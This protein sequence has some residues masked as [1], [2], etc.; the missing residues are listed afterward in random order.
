MI[1]DQLSLS[2]LPLKFSW[3]STQIE[4]ILQLFVEEAGTKNGFPCIFAQNAMKRKLVK[5]ILVPFS[6]Q[7]KTHEYQSFAVDLE[8]YLDGVHQ[9]NG[10]I[11]SHKPLLVI[12]EP[13]ADM[14]EQGEEKY[15]EIFIDSMQ[16]LLDNDDVAWSESISKDPGDPTWTMCFK[17]VEIFVNVSHPAH[18]QRR[19]RNLCDSLVFVLNPRRVFDV[20]APANTQ[21]IRISEKIRS[22]LTIY[23][24][25]SPSPLL[26]SY[27]LGEAQWQ[28]YMLPDNN[29]DTPLKC[30]LRFS[31]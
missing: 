23:D 22:N 3:A 19:S 8:E 5:F 28:Q 13:L 12:F 7:S 20:A 24:D 11:N 14:D 18:V 15:R 27:V 10:E 17:G 30:P 31:K 16:H 21:G 9:W 29:T 6:A 2:G 25:V 1:T 26:G 4:K